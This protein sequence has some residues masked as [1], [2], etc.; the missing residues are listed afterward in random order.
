M[1]PHPDFQVHLLEQELAEELAASPNLSGRSDQQWLKNECLKRDDFRCIL[2]GN[3]DQDHEHKYPDETLVHTNCAHI[4]PASLGCSTDG[5]N[6]C[7]MI[8][9]A[10]T[11]YFLD[12]KDTRMTP[13]DVNVPENAFTLASFLHTGFGRFDFSLDAVVSLSRK[14]LCIYSNAS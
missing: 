7:V 5:E 13:F 6:I 1:T 11:R 9:T 2:T 14:L 8:W 10:I 4:I 3:V 12:I